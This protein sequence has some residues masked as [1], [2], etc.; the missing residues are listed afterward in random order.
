MKCLFQNLR[1]RKVYVLLF[2]TTKNLKFDNS[3]LFNSLAKS[4]YDF[5]NTVK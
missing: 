5:K 2:S 1:K 4:Y 3:S